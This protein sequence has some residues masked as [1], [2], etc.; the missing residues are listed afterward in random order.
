MKSK[1]VC[2]KSTEK[3]SRECCCNC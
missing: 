3:F 1:K 2:Q